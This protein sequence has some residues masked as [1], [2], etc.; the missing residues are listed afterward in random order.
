MMKP[1]NSSGGSTLQP[2]AERDLQRLASLSVII[3]FVTLQ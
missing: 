3:N 1:L 2:G